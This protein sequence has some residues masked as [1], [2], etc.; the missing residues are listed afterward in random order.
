VETETCYARSD[1]VSVAYR[2][3]GEGP[4][5]LVHVPRLVSRAI[6]C[7]CAISNGVRDLGLELRAG[8]HVKDLVAGS[9]IEL[10]ERG[11][12]ELKGVPGE[13][14]LFAGAET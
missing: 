2:V 7:A 4:F 14:R 6:R 11:V 10:R 1:D 8:L 3:T 12:A 13:L 5:D 9:G